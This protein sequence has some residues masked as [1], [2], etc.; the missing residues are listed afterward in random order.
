MTYWICRHVLTEAYVAAAGW[1][2]SSRT[3][4]ESASPSCQ[5]PPIIIT[6]ENYMFQQQ[7]S[8]GSI[9][10]LQSCKKPSFILKV[11]SIIEI[12]ENTHVSATTRSLDV[13]D[14]SHY[15]TTYCPVSV[16]NATSR[17]HC[18][19]FLAKLF[20]ANPSHLLYWLPTAHMYSMYAR[21]IKNP[22]A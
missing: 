12:C 9:L 18:H 5:L 1:P 6:S 11:Q 10:L 13:I 19:N 22:D 4:C 2:F 8:Q 16:F 20:F 17:W 7:E 3:I 14:P 21:H 15:S